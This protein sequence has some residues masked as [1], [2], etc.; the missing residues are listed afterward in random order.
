VWLFS[1]GAGTV[2]FPFPGHDCCCILQDINTPTL[3]VR[4]QAGNSPSTPL[5]WQSGPGLSLKTAQE[6]RVVNG[7]GVP[8][9]PTHALGWG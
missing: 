6:W 2:G 7:Q 5:A 1:G 9:P 4:S 8:P 3:T